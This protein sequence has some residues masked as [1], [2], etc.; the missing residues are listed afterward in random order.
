MAG[1]GEDEALG[2][3]VAGLERLSVPLVRGEREAEGEPDSVSEGAPLRLPLCGAL[4]EVLPRGE[5][6]REGEPEGVE[7]PSGEAEALAEVE[8]VGAL[9]SVGAAVAEALGEAG[10]EAVGVGLPVAPLREGEP[11]A[12]PVAAEVAVL[13]ALVEAE[14]LPE[15]ESLAAG[16]GV[17]Q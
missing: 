15:G 12:A 5:R 4:R 2:A 17:W 1:E 7:L 14:A 8:L 13:L 3:P 16:E 9:E 6:D 10:G 11:V